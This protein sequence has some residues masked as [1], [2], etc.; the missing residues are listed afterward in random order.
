MAGDEWEWSGSSGCPIQFHAPTIATNKTQHG[1]GS[2]DINR[3]D[4]EEWELWMNIHSLSQWWHAHVLM[5][6]LADDRHN[7]EPG[8]EAIENPLDVG[9]V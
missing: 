3:E 6:T 5:S 8:K 2:L 1:N 9:Q 7:D 4:E